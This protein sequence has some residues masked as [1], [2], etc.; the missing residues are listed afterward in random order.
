[1]PAPSPPPQSL[2]AGEAGRAPRSVNTRRLTVSYATALLLVAL[3]TLGSHA[4]LSRGLSMH[5]LDASTINLAHRQRMLAEQIVKD[6]LLLRTI[7]A[8]H[9]RHQ[10]VLVD[11]RESIDRLAHVH[12]GLREGSEALGV[13]GPGRSLAGAAFPPLHDAFVC[14]A[15]AA[16]EAYARLEGGAT[17]ASL[18]TLIEQER[19]FLER[20]DA[21]V[22]AY[23]AWSLRRLDRTRSL[24]L[25]LGGLLLAVLGLEAALI[26]RP[27][28]RWIRRQML[29]LTIAQERAQLLATAAEHTRH[30]V[31]LAEANGSVLWLN[32]VARETFR[33]PDEGLPSIADAVPERVAPRVRA[34]VQA[35]RDLHLDDATGGGGSS[36]VDLVAVRDAGGRAR[37]YVLVVT[38]LSARAQRERSK[39][40]VQRRAGRADVAAAVLHNVGNTLNSLSLAAQEADLSLQ[41]S[42]LP[43]LARAVEMLGNDPDAAAALLSESPRGRKLPLYL[44]GVSGRLHAEQEELREHLRSVQTAV[45]HL[46][47]VVS[48]QSRS[49]ET[50]AADRAA[51]FEDEELG[52]LVDEALR[53]YG[54]AATRERVAVEVG[55]TGGALLVRIDR[56]ATLQ[57]LGN[58]LVNAVQS[59][60]EARE[61]G[62]DPDPT[63]RIRTGR[64]G[65]GAA[66]VEVVDGG[67]GIDPAVL[68]R[69]F[70]VG[71]ST[72]A[73]HEGIG[74]HASANA[75]SAGG[76]RLTASSD[77]PGAGATLRL[78][79]P[80]SGPRASSLPPRSEAA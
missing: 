59:V 57:V 20:M 4:L 61:A 67:V 27:T 50:A 7:P 41:R 19:R 69:L 16:E 76:G 52:V 70:Q 62:G 71:Y 40:E 46:H 60:A 72:K 47:H 28:V 42:R 8:V 63:L 21:L 5:R 37:R 54:G 15:R 29:D 34:A 6:A 43:G 31:L 44:H 1:M 80:L 78:E 22:A 58:L 66:F 13:P 35:G 64:S 75:A 56:H 17:P 74:L 26:F 25:S 33:D 53:V 3:L 18:H 24:Q 32:P 73:A 36:A 23:E 10:P 38:D 11:M 39:L 77:G 9:P 30:A 79:L 65:V 12:A 48:Q 51:A 49:V 2:P 45:T 14:F 68:P 55:G